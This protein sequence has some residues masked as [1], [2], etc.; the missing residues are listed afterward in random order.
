M[1]NKKQN[2]DEFMDA[3]DVIMDPKAF[4]DVDPDVE[5]EI[6][7]PSE[8]NNLDDNKPLNEVN[9]D[10]GDGKKKA[11]PDEDSD[12]KDDD[13]DTD[14]TDDETSKEDEELKEKIDDGEDAES[15][16]EL[17][18]D[19]AKYVQ[20]KLYSKLGIDLTKENTVSSIDSIVD[21]LELMVAE[22]SVPVFANKEIEEL[23]SFVENGGNLRNYFESKYIAEFDVDKVDLERPIDQERILREYFKAQNISDEVIEKKIDRYQEKDT[24]EDEAKDAFVLLKNIKEQ[25]GK[26][27]LLE[28]ENFIRE[29]QK[30]QQKFY[31]DVTSYILSLEDINGVTLNKKEKEQLVKDIFVPDKDGKTKYQKEYESSLI[32]NLTKSAFYTLLGDKYTERI[33]RKAKSDTVKEIKNKME[34]F[35]RNPRLKDTPRETNIKSFEDNLKEA[36]RFLISKK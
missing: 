30:Q 21:E 9:K 11:T 13:S 15:L 33:K 22:A 8:V 2:F 7:D 32:S 23:N 28:Q 1:A 24:L 14:E 17:E 26:K 16:G 4:S 20:E 25:E 10:E 5:L 34:N 3:T 6:K 27:L 35:K 19:L 31:D 18:P 36:T 12:N 29:R